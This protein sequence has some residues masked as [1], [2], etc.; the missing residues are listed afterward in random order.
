M[1]PLAQ[2]GYAQEVP[3]LA[4]VIGANTGPVFDV[5]DIQGRGTLILAEKGLFFAHALNGLVTVVP[6]GNAD[7]QRPPLRDYPPKAGFMGD[8]PGGRVL[9]WVANRWFL[10]RAVDDAVSVAPAGNAD[11]GDV[12][13]MHDLPG[14]RVLIAAEKG[15]FLARE[16]NSV[17]TIE[18]AAHADTGR[19]TQMWDFPSGGVLIRAAKGWFFAR[20]VDD[21][22]SVAFAGDANT[23]QIWEMRDF[24]GGGILIA[25]EKGLFL[26]RETNGVVTVALAGNV[27]TP[28]YKMLDLPGWVLI[29]AEK[30]LFLARAAN[31]GVTVEP[32]GNADIEDAVALVAFPGG[33]VL[34]QAAKGWFLARAMD[35]MVTFA[36][37]GN[38]D[39]GDVSAMH[40]LPGGG[41]LI[42][43]EKGLFL[44]REAN[45]G[46]TVE[47]AGNADTGRVWQ[48]RNFP[49]NRV[50]IA[51][52]RGL[53]LARE[54]NS[55]VTVEPAGNADTGRVAEMRDFPGGGVLIQAAKGWFFARAVDDMVNVAFAGNADTGKWK[56][57]DFP[58]GGVL[59][60]AEKGLFLARE[61]N[62]IV[63]I[64]PAGDV[65][66]GSVIDVRDVP[67]RGVLIWAAN[68]LFVIVPTSLSRAVVT[69]QNKK[70]VDGSSIDREVTIEF[71]M[72]H[73]CAAIA[74]FLGLKVRVT[75]PGEKSTDRNRLF[76]TPT[77]NPKVAEITLPGLRVDKAHQWSFQLIASSN[78]RVRLVGEPQTLTFVSGP[79][80]ERWWKTLVTSLGAVLVLMNIALFVLARRSA[81][82]WRMATDDN[83]GTWV[84]R[85]ATLLI[86]HVPQAQLWIIDLYYQRIRARMQAPG[87]FLPLPLSAR[88]GSVRASTEAMAPP[89]SGRRLWVQGGSGM[90]KTALF[91]NITENHFRNN[92][93]AF[94]AYAKWGCVL[95]QFAARDFAGSG[96]D[97]DDPGWVVDAVRAILSSEGLTFASSALLSRFL[98][99]GTLGVAIDGLNEVDRTRAVAAF[100]RTFKDAPILVTSQQLGSDR[101]ATWRLPPDIREFTY[102]LLRL[103]L[104]E[105]QAEAVMKRIAA[106]G[107][108]DAIRSG[109]DVRL[110]IDLVRSDPFHAELP[111]DRMGLYAAVIKASWPD[112]PD[113]ARQE[114]Q[115]R[116]AAAAWRMVSERKPNED[117]RRL[118]PDVDLPA[119][120][121]VALADAPEN[122]NRAVRFIRRLGVGA[123]EFVHDQMH[124]YLAARWF[125]QDGFS[126]TELEKMVV[127]S[128]IWTQSADA[129]R[130]L[131]GF[132]AALLDDERLKALWVRVE[133]KEEWDILRRSLKAEAERRGLRAERVLETG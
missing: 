83:W 13:A 26:A 95:V 19:V 14:G 133:D 123:F 12:S 108:K 110:I 42:A 63:T 49:G 16:V 50:L 43:A 61:A 57:R 104:V 96:E 98:E 23:D 81:W 85:V 90:G 112:V 17:V 103:Y 77:E 87:P 33:R 28:V 120:L 5:R 94:A 37:A 21:V 75:A 31:S 100:T 86:S 20:T 36:P 74:K 80:W 117:M 34:I 48:M 3:G 119:T 97:R 101:F 44:A 128:T 64:A 79:W 65:H 30:G 124:A 89:W 76:I 35:D 109:Y 102:D 91:R 111:A 84:L 67:G 25:A 32:A 41:V 129:R 114:Q 7:L 78:D 68:G 15:L 2:M 71:H 52:E 93:T 8:F 46:V 56:M 10:A 9:I 82:A 39:T 125:A 73:D 45:S 107:L 47:P 121:L 106:S 11:T 38:A 116:T 59:I 127:G 54:A 18:P 105:G 29:T 51:A 115:S 27:D 40:D 24:P 55:G 122:D 70:N 4:C 66:T 126:V 99:S 88:D 22:V 92:N 130:T 72:V 131:W 1:M 69:I 53:F 60:A 113:N 6:T 58:D 62:G 118:R 132:A